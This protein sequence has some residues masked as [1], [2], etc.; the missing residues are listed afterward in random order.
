MPPLPI[1]SRRL[2]ERLPTSRAS[3]DDSACPSVSCPLIRGREGASSNQPKLSQLLP[4]LLRHGSDSGNRAAA[5]V[6][7]G[8][9]LC[10]IAPALEW[11]S[12]GGAHNDELVL[13]DQN[14]A[15]RTVLLG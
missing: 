7:G 9:L 11:A 1:G 2:Q 15:R 5:Q 4:Q 6:L 3:H 13:E 14:A 12:R 10:Q 8:L